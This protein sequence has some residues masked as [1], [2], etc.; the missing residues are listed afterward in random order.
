MTFDQRA[1]AKRPGMYPG[2]AT[3]PQTTAY[4]MNCLI[5]SFVSG[6][7]HLKQYALSGLLTKFR[8]MC[9]QLAL[10]REIASFD[11]PGLSQ[12]EVD[13]GLSP[14]ELPCRV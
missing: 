9:T 1:L 12:K 11:Q 8:A 3:Q 14:F 7:A 6:P 13:T 10:R 4:L 5:V 2:R